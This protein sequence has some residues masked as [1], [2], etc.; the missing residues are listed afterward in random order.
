MAVRFGRRP[1]NPRGTLAQEQA[2]LEAETPTQLPCAGVSA[3]RQSPPCARTFPGRCPRSAPHLRSPRRAPPPPPGALVPGPARGAQASAEAPSP[4]ASFSSRGGRGRLV[5]Q[6]RAVCPARS[7][8]S[9]EAPGAAEAAGPPAAS[10]APLPEAPE[11][12]PALAQAAAPA[13]ASQFTL[14][15][16]RPCAGQDEA[17]SAGRGKPGGNPCEAAGDGEEE[18]GEDDADLLDTSDPPGGGESAASL[19]DLEDEET[20][21]GGEGSGGAAPARGS[22]GGCVSKTCTYEGCS[23][24]TSQVAKQRKPWMCKKHRNKMYKDKYKKKK[25]DQAQ[26]CSG[27]A[28]A[29]GSGS[30]KLEESTDNILSIVKQRSGSFGDRPARPTLLEQVLNQK[31]LSLLRSPEVVEFLQKQQQLLNQQVLEQRQQQFPGTSV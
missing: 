12:G 19:E 27:T 18:T 5:G 28:P 22:G 10:G 25:S 30:V 9:T 3:V 21:S 24:T 8:G 15:V 26:N 16:M 2:R 6:A 29:S 7:L 20:H 11:P 17:G 23:E 13:P 1:G 14:L 31:R 4:A